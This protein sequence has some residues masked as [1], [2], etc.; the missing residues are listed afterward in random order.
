MSVSDTNEPSETDWARLREMT[1]EA[2]DLTDSPELDDD[3][4]D[5]A[6]LRLPKSVAVTLEVDAV[7]LAWFNA[8]KNGSE[9]MNAALRIYAEA[10]QKAH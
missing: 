9:L 2:I 3:F 1:D 10:H 6:T 7:T 8:Q 5:K 4:F